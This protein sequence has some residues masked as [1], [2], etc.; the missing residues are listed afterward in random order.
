MQTS[1]LYVRVSHGI[2]HTKRQFDEGAI[3][4][5]TTTLINT[6]RTF[7]SQVKLIALKEEHN[8]FSKQI[9]KSVTLLRDS[10]HLGYFVYID[11]KNCIIIRKIKF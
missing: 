7:H 1:Y 4:C 3:G 11:N 9:F 6:H 5:T 8:C 2:E 10:I